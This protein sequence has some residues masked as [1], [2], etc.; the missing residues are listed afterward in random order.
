[1]GKEEAKLMKQLAKVYNRLME[2]DPSS[3]V[4][5]QFHILSLQNIILSHPVRSA[6]NKS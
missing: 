3:A 6:I 4:P 2:L 5:I 1:M